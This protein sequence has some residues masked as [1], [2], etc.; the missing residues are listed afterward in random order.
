[1]LT[2]LA[3]KADGVASP[4]EHRVGVTPGSGCHP[5]TEDPLPGLSS[6]SRRAQRGAPWGS[7]LGAV[8]SNNWYHL[9]F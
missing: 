3:R 9:L 5:G 8:F 1:M 4:S 7:V 6:P 2:I